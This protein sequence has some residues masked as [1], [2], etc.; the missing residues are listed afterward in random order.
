MICN[1]QYN[2]MAKYTKSR[3]WGVVVYPESAPENWVEIL[4]ESRIQFA[5]SPLH[6][7]DVNPD[8]EI[9][10]SHWHVILCWDGP[11]TDVAVK[12][13]TDKI[14]APN[15]IKLES[16]RGAY[17][18]FTHMDHPDKYQYDDKEIKVFNGFDISS[19]IALTKEERYEAITAI[20]R[21]INENKVTEYLDLLNE[22]MTH[23]YSLFKVACD[24]TILFTSVIR[25]NRHKTDR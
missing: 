9:K 24:N 19:Y 11:V 8:G 22:L 16:V 1:H 17:R 10:K 25:S 2:S 18:Y 21:Y 5:V 14:E 6:D 12:K 3:T 4:D 7:K 20:I 23:D 15:P 13:L